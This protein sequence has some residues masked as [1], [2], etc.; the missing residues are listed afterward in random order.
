MMGRYANGK[1]RFEGCSR[2]GYR[3][4]AKFKKGREGIPVEKKA[5]CLTGHLELK[6]AH[7]KAWVIGPGG[8]EHVR[9]FDVPTEL[10]IREPRRSLCSYA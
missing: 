1:C 8:A 10:W 7:E 9:S 2:S 6:T 4:E 5:L 3:E